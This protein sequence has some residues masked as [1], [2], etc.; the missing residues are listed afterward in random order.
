MGKSMIEYM[1]RY[2]HMSHPSETHRTVYLFHLLISS[3]LH[4]A[5]YNIAQ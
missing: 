3:P 4:P 1:Y 5:E 2:T